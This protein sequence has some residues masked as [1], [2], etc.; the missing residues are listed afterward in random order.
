LVCGRVQD[1]AGDPVA[2][3]E[4]QLVNKERIAVAEVYADAKGNFAF[5]PLP[6]GEYDLTTKS[7][8]W[9]LFWPIE[10][11]SSK[12]SKICKR[13]LDVTLGIR[14]CGA[15]VSKKGYHAKF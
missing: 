4:L 12:P 7:E 2:N 11:T 8:G 3:A 1:Q 13:P 14:V 5:G 15:G 9:H 10:V 6:K